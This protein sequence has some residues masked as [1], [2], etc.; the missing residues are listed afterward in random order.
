MHFNTLPKGPEKFKHL[1]PSSFELSCNALLH[2]FFLP[3]KHQTSFCLRALQWPFLCL[4]LLYPWQVP[5]HQLYLCL[6]DTSSDGPSQTST[7]KPSPQFFFATKPRLLLH[8]FYH[9]YQRQSCLF[10]Y[11]F[12]LFLP[13]QQRSSVST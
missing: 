10:I 12:I 11:L 8:S 7:H 5:S 13:P 6:N 9:H 1:V 4:E 2:C 3:Q